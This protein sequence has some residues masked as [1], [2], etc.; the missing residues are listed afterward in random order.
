MGTLK[1][2]SLNNFSRYHAPVLAN[3]SCCVLHPEYLEVCTF[4]PPFSNSPSPQPLPLVT[5]SL[6]SFYEVL[7]LLLLFLIPSS[8]SAVRGVPERDKG[9]L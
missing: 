7:L 9:E 8:H 1:I 5:T 2:Y 4:W 3:A 6:I